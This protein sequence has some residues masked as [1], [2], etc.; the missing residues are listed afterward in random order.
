MSPALSANAAKS[1]LEAA[2]KEKK[3]MQGLN[4]RLGNYIDR[5][6]K[7]EEQNRKLVAD[8]E[9]LRGRWGKDTSEIKVGL[10]GWWHLFILKIKIRYSESLSDARKNIDNAARQKAE[11]DVKVAR[12][13]E[14]LEE[15]RNR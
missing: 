13:R 4:D 8:L 9:D 10:F 11:V 15:Y 12:L 1:F 2:D 14:D 5:V 3:E 6:K 7:L